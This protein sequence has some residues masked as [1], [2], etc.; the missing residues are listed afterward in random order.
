MTLMIFGLILAV[1]V[2]G[3]AIIVVAVGGVIF[4][5]ISPSTATAAGVIINR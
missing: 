3:A 1:L 5:G 2:G 4:A